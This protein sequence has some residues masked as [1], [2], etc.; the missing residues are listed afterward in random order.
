LRFG[1]I[2]AELSISKAS[3]IRLLKVL[4]ARGYAT[5]D[6][7]TGAYLA[8]P[9]LAALGRPGR[10]AD[11]MRRASERVLARLSEDAR[12]TALAIHW[13]GRR[14]QCLNKV[15]HQASA[16]MQQVGT[17]MLD[18]D[19][20]PWGWIFY[21]TLD[22]ASREEACRHMHDAA[23]FGRKLKKRMTFYENKGFSYDDQTMFKSLRRLTAVVRSATGAIIGAVGIGGNPVT[24]PDGRVDALGRRV[25]R[26]ADELSRAM[27]WQGPKRGT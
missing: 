21:G 2:F 9:H 26:A 10:E 20:T 13:N 7:R 11:L 3:A 4:I 19:G 15:V 12:S 18:L 14:M 22:E 25:R 8:G 5:K 17:V 1:E 16:P 27:G 6:D 23:A 24:I